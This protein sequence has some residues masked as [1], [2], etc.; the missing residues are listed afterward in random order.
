M[1]LG[2]W[3]LIQVVYNSILYTTT[4]DYVQKYSANP[5]RHVRIAI[6]RSL[7]W[8]ISLG[9]TGVCI[10]F[11]RSIPPIRNWIQTENR[12]FGVGGYHHPSYFFVYSRHLLYR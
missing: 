5:S 9:K 4:R 1:R 11:R 12:H 10:H 3:K 2:T 7:I 8:S 6:I